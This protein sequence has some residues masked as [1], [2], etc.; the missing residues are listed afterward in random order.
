[1]IR[2]PQKLTGP[3]EREALA[4]V[5]GQ[6]LLVIRRHARYLRRQD[7]PTTQLDNLRVRRTKNSAFHPRQNKHW[8]SSKRHFLCISSNLI[9]RETPYLDK[10]ER[11][12]H[13][14]MC[15]IPYTPTNKSAR[16]LLIKSNAP[17]P[18]ETLALSGSPATRDVPLVAFQIK[19]WLSGY[20]LDCRNLAITW[21]RSARQWKTWKRTTLPQKSTYHPKR[22]TS[23][24]IREGAG[25]EHLK[26]ISKITHWGQKLVCNGCLMA[27]TR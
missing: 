9:S 16:L 24:K 7:N 8:S 12:S 22:K 25:L 18:S 17:A 13:P 5:T 3:K 23:S 2:Y 19:T 14:K 21:K 10:N 20:R 27:M 1:M 26:N 15:E 11:Q 4:L 6:K